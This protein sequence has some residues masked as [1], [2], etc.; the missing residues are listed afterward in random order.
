MNFIIIIATAISIW[1]AAVEAEDF[2]IPL[3]IGS[4][5]TFAPRLII[6]PKV[7]KQDIDTLTSAFKTS[8][9][10]WSKFGE[11]LTKELFPELNKM[12]AEEFSTEELCDSIG[13]V[14]EKLPDNH[15][16]VHTFDSSFDCGKSSA[17][18]GSVGKNLNNGPL[19]A[20]SFF[21]KKVNGVLIS[22]IAINRLPSPGDLWFGFPE[23]IKEIV[24]SGT[25][26]IID[27]RGIHG[28]DDTMTAQMARILYGIEDNEINLAPSLT[29]IQRQTPEALSL[30]LNTLGTVVLKRKFEGEFSDKLSVYYKEQWDLIQK[31]KTPKTPQEEKIVIDQSKLNLSKVFSHPIRLLIDSECESSCENT[32]AFFEN[33]PNSKTVGENTAGSIH[34]G[35]VGTV[36]LKNS[37]V[38]VDIPTKIYNYSDKRFIEKKGYVPNIPVSSGKDA[39]K[40][41][42]EELGKK[43]SLVGPPS[44]PNTPA[45]KK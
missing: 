34:F 37:N 15:I 36:W 2:I 38:F 44:G 40:I 6:P 20:W 14:L 41:A 42:L 27:L 24:K 7:V 45:K 19:L 8:Y 1:T 13:E 39:Y 30:F 43:P 4:K 26:L 28:G 29:T 16:R 17:K 3:S 25:P 35:Q 10:G 23:K 5:K 21:K 18:K 9:G 12:G 22:V 33:H 31:A 11:Q 32:V